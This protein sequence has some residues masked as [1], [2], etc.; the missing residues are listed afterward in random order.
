MTAA[1][2]IGLSSRRV[3][4]LRTIA[5][6][7]AYVILGQC[8]RTLSPIDRYLED[9]WGRRARRDQRQLIWPF[10]RVDF[11]GC[12]VEVI[13][14]SRCWEAGADELRQVSPL[15]V[16]SAVFAC[17]SSFWRVPSG[18]PGHSPTGQVTGDR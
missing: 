16:A 5:A 18:L 10:F 17:G 2:Q 8:L 7:K 14:L 1:R 6:P 13:P 15:G 3:S 12:V 11:A 9:D 4:L